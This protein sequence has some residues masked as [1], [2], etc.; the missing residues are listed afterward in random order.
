MSQEDKKKIAEKKKN[1]DNRANGKLTTKTAVPAQ[2][3]AKTS[4]WS[5]LL[6]STPCFLPAVD[7]NSGD[8]AHPSINGTSCGNG[9]VNAYTEPS[10]SPNAAFVSGDSSLRNRVFVSDS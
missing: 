9:D 10:E 8:E 4:M 7:D 5:G 1:D 6:S 3:A 2:G